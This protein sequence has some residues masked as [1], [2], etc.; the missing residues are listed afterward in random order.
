MWDAGF[1]PAGRPSPRGR[2]T[3]I[4]AGSRYIVRLPAGTNVGRYEV[5]GL[6]GAG[7]M[8][9]VYRARDL[10]LGRDVALKVLPR[11]SASDPI[12]LRRFETES[13]ATGAL[14]HPNVLSVFDVGLHEECPYIVA[15]FLEGRTLRQRLDAEKLA[16]RTAVDYA[17]QIAEGLAA[18]HA[19]G[20]VH[21]DLK[22]ANL[23]VT[24][25]GRVKI[26]DFGLAK[27]CLPFVVR[28]AGEAATTW[29]TQPG[30]PMGTAGYM[31]PEQ[32]E[33][34]E[35]DH[36]ADIF[37]FGAVLY[38]M[39]SRRMAFPARTA[40]ESMA[41]IL[42]DEPP[43]LSRTR[44]AVP[45]PLERIVQRC[46]EKRPER[47]FQSAHDVAFALRDALDAMQADT[48]RPPRPAKRPRGRPSRHAIRSIAVLALENLSG[49]PEQEYLADGLTD[50]LIGDLAKIG[51]LRVI[52]RT[53]AMRYKGTRT[54]LPQIA[55]D[56]DVD[57]VV[58]GS[59]VCSGERVRVS[60]RLID[61]ATDR[62][63]WA[64]TYER[65][66]RDVLALQRE[67]S[68]AIAR[69]VQVAL[70]PQQEAWTARVRPVDPEAHLAYV[71]GRY[72]CAKRTA[73]G[74]E[75][76]LELFAQAIARDPGYAAPW[77]GV[78][79][80]Y[81]LL[82]A[83]G[84]DV[85]PARL[86]VPKAKAAA[87]TALELDD[88]L[89][90]AH[91]ALAQILKDHEWDFAAAEKSYRTAIALDPGYATAHHWYSNYLSAMG[92]LDEAQAE[93]ER[94]LALDPLSLVINQLVARPHY[95]ARRF[96]EAVEAS[97]RAISMDPAF[98][99][100]YLQ[101]GMAYAAKGMNEEAVVTLQRFSELAGGGTLARAL[102]AFAHARA[103]DPVVAR[104]LLDEL[105]G[106]AR[107]SYV[108][109]YQFAVAHIGLGEL[110]EAFAWLDKAYDE[111]SD[112]LVYLKVEPTFDPLRP[113]RRFAELV[114]RVGLP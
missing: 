36:R 12:R 107:A 103:G 55:R 75:R 52:S 78:A 7:G 83:I 14:N 72:Y 15:E 24:A 68:W 51:E 2:G 34:R 42:R 50:A 81:C 114:H 105:R 64:E 56:L 6:V 96:D 110:D 88:T 28:E 21:R 98:P 91:A 69:E 76:G 59:M 17:I 4:A 90:E 85:L 58:E 113:D 30:I 40:A 53:S 45:A 86:A 38:E 43:S 11:T 67:V 18:A 106:I 54:P 74:F 1:P 35:A 89:A 46:L 87:L 19:K 99:I 61:A 108:P 60:A 10:R 104:R 95:F 70:T 80:T 93:A 82:S 111:R 73:E 33:G 112:A 97:R 101:L 77:A 48:A 84:Y 94:A 22:P 23:F 25:D 57:A 102:L 13:R 16:V 3:I 71:K 5:V 65:D 32:V 49:D 92:R 20:V 27:L 109:A 8:G 66:L 44:R 63:L 37:A 41:A 100:A 29:T 9:E 39:L 62:H 26:L 79:G 31:A 47:R